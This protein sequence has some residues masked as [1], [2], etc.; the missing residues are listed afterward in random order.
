MAVWKHG[1]VIITVCLR[2]TPKAV[3]KLI[4]DRFESLGLTEAS[5]LPLR[6]SKWY[7]F[8]EDR[9]NLGVITR[10]GMKTADRNLGRVAE[11]LTADQIKTAEALNLLFAD[12]MQDKRSL[13]KDYQDTSGLVVS[14]EL[15]GSAP[16]ATA[17]L[18]KVTTREIVVAVRISAVYKPHPAQA[19]IPYVLPSVFDGNAAPA[20][21]TMRLFERPLSE[22]ERTK[23][24]T[25]I[26]A[27]ATFG[28]RRTKAR[29]DRL[30]SAAREKLGPELA[31][32]WLNEK[33][34]SQSPL[35]RAREDVEGLN[36]ALRELSDVHVKV[37][38]GH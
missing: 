16:D 30:I 31:T 19:P 6:R 9:I 25:A 24:R 35:D 33:R 27:V 8:S 26:D 4:R 29:V 20:I 23:L 1:D 28:R 37:T 14:V 12:I 22:T 2:G 34:Y 38:S 32:R 15:E 18:L 21:D 3:F 17:R 11:M 10:Y 7:R 36:R 5:V 13:P